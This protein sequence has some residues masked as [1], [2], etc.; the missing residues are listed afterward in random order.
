MKENQQSLAYR[1][2]GRG[3]IM[4]EPIPGM[5]IGRRLAKTYVDQFNRK[6]VQINGRY[7]LLT[8]QHNYLSVD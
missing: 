6:Y 4:N 8:T 5:P 2:I 7:E 3:F 1:Q